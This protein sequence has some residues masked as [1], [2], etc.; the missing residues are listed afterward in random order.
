MEEINGAYKKLI[1]YA[2]N[3]ERFKE[4]TGKRLRIIQFC[5]NIML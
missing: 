3:V 1:L 5:S 2:S 4:F